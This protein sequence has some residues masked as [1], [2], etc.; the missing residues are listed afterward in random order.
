MAK[1]NTSIQELRALLADPKL[2]PQQRK[3]YE[4]DLK[5]LSAARARTLLQGASIEDRPDE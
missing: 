2:P 3:E 1:L 4:Q 5:F